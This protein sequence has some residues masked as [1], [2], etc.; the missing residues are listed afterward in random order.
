MTDQVTAQAQDP[1]R[2]A[3]DPDDF[4]PLTRAQ[5]TPQEP[6]ED[7]QDPATGDGVP[8]DEDM[9]LPND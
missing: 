5:V 1:T 2:P 4:D 6:P 8:D 7:G 3:T 9:P